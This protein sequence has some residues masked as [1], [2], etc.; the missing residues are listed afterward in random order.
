M[1]DDT[2][3]R[4]ERNYSG[5]AG[6]Q[7]DPGLHEGPATTARTWMVTAA[8]AAVL[9]AVMYGITAQRQEARTDQTPTITTGSN[10]TPSQ[11]GGRNTG[12]APLNPTVVNPAQKTGG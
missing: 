6:P 11:D 7:P 10:Q 3:L 8:I 2:R 12:N 1:A 9:L 4:T 5:E